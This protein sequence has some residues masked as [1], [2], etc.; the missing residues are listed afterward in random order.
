MKSDTIESRYESYYKAVMG[1]ER[2]KHTYTRRLNTIIEL[3]KG[4]ELK[5][6]LDVGCGYGFRTLGIAN[7][8]AE[9]VTGIDL[10]NERILEAR[11]YAN[12][13]S[14]TNA[15]FK[16]MNA[17][18][19]T[20]PDNTFDIV[21]ADEMIHHVENIQTVF[22]EI[23]RVTKPGGVTVISDHNKWSIPSQLI[24]LIYFGKHKARIFSAKQ[25][26][27]F[28]SHAKFQDI[29]YKHII[30]TMPFSGAPPML[31]KV[32]YFLEFLIER[33]PIVRL[34]CGVYVIRGIK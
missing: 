17:E 34:Q 3:S 32:N 28:L 1:S 33:I 7:L 14:A 16:Q 31:L 20:F 5:N 29:F 12:D 25:V 18:S 24:R 19:M 27:G 21:I 10:D 15:T 4:F 6:I 30:F 22:N 2:A 8:G 9:S 26:L 11:K 13:M 23:Y